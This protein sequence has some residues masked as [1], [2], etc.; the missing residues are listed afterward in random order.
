MR[1]RKDAR[2][3]IFFTPFCAKV[4][5][6]SACAAPRS[7]GIMDVASGK[8]FQLFSQICLQTCSEVKR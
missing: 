6:E 5:Q 8:R 3:R 7:K 4:A 1:C 2:L